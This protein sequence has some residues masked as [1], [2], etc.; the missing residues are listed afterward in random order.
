MA[1]H[2]R[3]SIKQVDSNTWLIGDLILRRSSGHSDTATW[4]D[5]IDNS[6]YT[7]T[8]A[9]T[10]RPL[11][12]LLTPDHPLFKQVYDA[13]D[14]SAVWFIG[15]NTVCKV[16]LWARGLTP[17]ATTL[18]FVQSKQPDFRTPDVLYTAERD[19]R[20]FLFLTRLPG[21]NLNDAWPSLSEDWRQYY[22]RAVA[23][24]CISMA[25]WKGNTIGGVDSQGI[26][27]GYL[28]PTG[29]PRWED[30]DAAKLQEVCKTIGTDYLNPVFQHA[31]LGPGNIIVDGEHVGVIDW[32]IAGYFP[33]EWIRTKF[34]IS[35]GIN[36]PSSA[37]D[38]TTRWRE[39]V[40]KEL[41]NNSGFEQCIDRWKLWFG[42]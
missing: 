15:N 24:I 16:K 18:K 25:D 32:E 2:V 30:Y 6:N 29:P 36:L 19:D 4:N 13:G 39:E 12:T 20:Y 40:I 5:T 8:A 9:P 22:A 7:L 3:E 21:R 17:E 28:I 35:W 31:D 37:T 14:A 33:K 1:E 10:P 23:K 34:H 42:Y 38:H 11:A 27:E 41:K 26:P